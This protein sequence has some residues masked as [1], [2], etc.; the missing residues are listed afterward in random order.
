MDLSNEDKNNE[1]E[2]FG[3][4]DR[5]DEVEALANARYVVGALERG[6]SMNKDEDE[7]IEVK[8]EDSS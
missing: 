6:Q 2:F 3:D 5:E 7:A 1:N 4:Q 8:Q